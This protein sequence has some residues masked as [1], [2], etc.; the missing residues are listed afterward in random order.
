MAIAKRTADALIMRIAEDIVPRRKLNEI[1][2]SA[3]TYPPRLFGRTRRGEG[4][5]GDEN[6]EPLM[7]WRPLAFR[8]SITL[9][10]TFATLRERKSPVFAFL[11]SPR[12]ERAGIKSESE[13]EFHYLRRDDD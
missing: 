12:T 1:K 3:P 5:G 9:S 6:R 13:V 4:E 2:S 11:P 8:K 7:K 10:E